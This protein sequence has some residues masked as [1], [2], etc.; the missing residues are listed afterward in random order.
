M[1]AVTAE[2]IERRHYA[3]AAVRAVCEAALVVAVYFA[4]PLTHHKRSFVVLRIALGL[5]VFAFTLAVELRAI[6]RSRRPMLRAAVAL[7]L[8][9]PVFIVVFAWT[10][11]T[12]S[13]SSPRAFGGELSH[14]SALYFTVTV[15]A[16]VGFGDIT[17]K[18]DAARLAVTAQML[19]DLAVVAGVVRLIF[20]AARSTSAPD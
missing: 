4:V 5:A 10:Y 1:A 20:G 9:L 19:L 3:I 17:A 7:A 13:L 8:V 16:T 6:I 14:I 18:T 2:K 15:F 12:M 11:L